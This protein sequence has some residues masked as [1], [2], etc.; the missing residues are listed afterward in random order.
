[1]AASKVTAIRAEAAPRADSPD[2][3]PI[4]WRVV[5]PG[6]GS[7]D[8]DMVYA[9][10]EDEEYARHEYRQL[11]RAGHPVRLERVQCGPLP[12]RAQRALTEAHNHNPQNPGR[13]D[14]RSI[15]GYWE[16]QS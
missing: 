14:L 8:H 12:E 15:P 11:R 1:M 5:A 9:D 7:Y 13:N 3:W 2:S 6:A 4:I 16:A 10:T